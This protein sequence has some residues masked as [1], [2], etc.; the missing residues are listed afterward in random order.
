MYRRLEKLFHK[1]EY[2]MASACERCSDALIIRE[3]QNKATTRCHYTPTRM[4]IMKKIDNSK[5]EWGCEQFIG[6][7]WE[8][9]LGSHFGK[10][11]ET[12]C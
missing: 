4:A 12:I 3:M 8:C 10:Q 11:T 7:W 6:Y 1:T 5:C 2:P 9:K